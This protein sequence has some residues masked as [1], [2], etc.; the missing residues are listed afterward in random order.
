MPSDTFNFKH[1]T[2]LS[3]VAAPKPFVFSGTLPT[4]HTV[5]PSPTLEKIPL[6]SEPLQNKIPS[7]SSSDENPFQT[8]NNHIRD[9]FGYDYQTL[10][11]KVRNFN[12][13]LAT[14]LDPRQKRA[15]LFN[16]LCQHAL[17]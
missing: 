5:I 12:S 3:Q 2:P 11:Q 4:T 9:L 16:F 17:I 1:A 14:V 10:E 15:Q 13:T 7:E 8:L 6:P